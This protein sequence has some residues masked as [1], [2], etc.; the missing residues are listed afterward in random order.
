MVQKFYIADCTYSKYDQA[1]KGR[2]I[3]SFGRYHK[4]RNR[5][6]EIETCKMPIRDAY[7]TRSAGIGNRG[8]RCWDLVG[9]LAL[10]FIFYIMN[11]KQDM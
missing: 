5:K 4:H 8:S 10:G 7:Q 9:G 3:K 11:P 2:R 1:P 6:R